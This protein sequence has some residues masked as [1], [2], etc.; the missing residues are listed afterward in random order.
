ME[1]SV[2]IVGWSTIVL[3]VV[4]IVA[5]LNGLMSGESTDQIGPLLTM[6]PQ[7]HTGSIRSFLEMFQYIR[8]WSLYTILYF[9]VVLWGAIQFV[10]FHAIGRTILE[11]VGWVGLLNAC[12]DTVLSYMIWKNMQAMLSAVAG[13]MGMG[14]VGLGPLG[15]ATIIAGFFFWIV[16]ASGMIVYLRKPK[17]RE[18][19]R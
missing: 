10:R 15:M 2:R 12:V 9:A 11:F 4:V 7:T 17:L 13:P 14:G 1:R 5:E 18:L 8:A 3:S 19:M 6:L 16:T